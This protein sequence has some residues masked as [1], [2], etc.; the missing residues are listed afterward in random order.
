MPFLSVGQKGS[1]QFVQGVVK[2][3]LLLESGEL[4]CFVLLVT[5]SEIDGCSGSE[6]AEFNGG[7]YFEKVT[8]V[9]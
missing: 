1:V 9:M 8:Y 6:F 7:L 2:P 4:V 5:Q 3:I